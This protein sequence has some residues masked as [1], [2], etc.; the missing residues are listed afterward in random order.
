VSEY[1][2]ID[3]VTDALEE[4]GSKRQGSDWQCPNHD[5]RN[6][7]LTVKDR[8]DG[9]VLMRCGAGCS[10]KDVL[11][12]LGLSF[13]DLYPDDVQR[14]PR[15]GRS[16]SET[17]QES[18]QLPAKGTILVNDHPVPHRSSVMESASAR[19]YLH[20][21]AVHP[22]VAEEARLYVNEQGRLIF[23]Q[24]GWWTARSL[25]GPGRWTNRPGPRPPLY[26]SPRAGNARMVG[27]VESPSDALALDSAGLPCFATLG[28]RLERA[29]VPSL[30]GRDVILFPHNDRPHPA[31]GTIIGEEW[32]FD[33]CFKLRGLVSSVSVVR[34]PSG[35]APDR[36]PYEYG[37]VAEYLAKTLPDAETAL[38]GLLSGHKDVLVE[39]DL[40]A[41]LSARPEPPGAS[42]PM[43]LSQVEVKGLERIEQPVESGPPLRQ[44]LSSRGDGP[45]PRPVDAEWIQGSTR[46]IQY[47]YPP[48]LPACVRVM[49]V[50]P[51]GA[52]K[53][54]WALH[55]AC[56]LSRQGIPVAYFSQENPAQVDQLRLRRM[57]PDLDY[58][59]FLHGEG[60]DLGEH[61]QVGTIGE[62]LQDE[63]LAIADQAARNGQ[64]P[65]DRWGLIVFDTLTGC[66]SGDENENAA[67]A[68]LD[69][70][71]L[72]P[73]VEE[74]GATVLLLH[75]TGHGGER[76]RRGA[77]APRGASAI[78]QKI[79]VVLEFRPQGDSAFVITCNRWQ[80]IGPSPPG[81]T[82]YAVVD[83]EDDHLKVA[84]V[85]GNISGARSQAA[86]EPPVAT[87]TRD[88][89]VE[90]VA[91]AMV[92]AVTRGG[93]LSVRK[94]RRMLMETGVQAGIELQKEASVRLIE[95]T[96]PRLEIVEGRVEGQRAKVWQLAGTARTGALQAA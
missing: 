18:S 54:M 42:R 19:A 36:D 72:M 55:V 67:F 15:S 14:V 33:A 94:M 21:H 3:V 9:V 10:T 26:A 4:L 68:A 78:G 45:W 88:M 73:L 30:E 1:D 65:V 50:G 37:D 16:S 43:V 29:A 38:R 13:A 77:T 95:E 7:S 75:H 60:V 22:N 32:L 83:T 70:E 25:N 82:L 64:K 80:R 23:P 90:Q 2:P 40:T 34:M 89:R 69:R 51:A 44:T 48:Y 86:W 59:R 28:S 91:S 35:G 24:N 5:D 92:Q 66:W 63:L 62:W 46:D 87:V 31:T 52:G 93:P 84:P 11:D 81:P 39:S 74:T 27:L 71:V 61:Q 47:V 49:A 8:G 12:Q 53:S 56:D 17:G 96:P 85:E 79:D 57:G 6:P 58:L 41:R 76:P 20:S